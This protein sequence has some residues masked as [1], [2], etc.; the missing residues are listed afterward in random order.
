MRTVA[1]YRGDPCAARMYGGRAMIGR[2]ITA[3]TL[4]SVLIVATP[5]R[6]PAAELE[7]V[8]TGLELP[9]SMAFAPDGRLFV[10]EQHLGTIRIV[11]NGRLLP[12]PFARIDVLGTFEQGLLGIAVH[13]RFPE[14]PWIY[15][16][17][18][19]PV[20]RINRLIRIRAEGDR[21]GHREVLLDLLT[22]EAGYHN[23]GDLVFGSD[24][25]LYLTVGDVHDAARA[26][27]VNDLGGKVLRLAPDGS[28]PVD[29][30]FGPGN[31]VYSIGHR[32]SFG[33]CV[34]SATGDLWETEN[35]PSSYD[36]VNL[37]RPGANFGWPEQL[38]PGGRDRGFTD[39][40]LDFPD[41]IVPTGCVVWDGDLYFG[42]YA[43]AHV[44]RL[45]LPAGVGAR[46]RAIARLQ[47]GITDLAIGPE[48]DLYVAALDG[49]HR[50][51]ERNPAPIPDPAPVSSGDP[52]TWL[53]WVAA[54]TIAIVLLQLRLSR[55]RR[56][57]R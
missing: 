27:N 48:G 52:W 28:I 6:A 37:L 57:A 31:P 43:D 44:R 14:E 46:A 38:G 36:E 45:R 56:L 55:A 51:R 34:D 7:P 19:D 54:G 21:A 53:P 47:D 4:L 22:T 8:V 25:M 23:G 32:N 2:A 15:A 11:E 18:S 16:Y 12:E 3:T 10:A 20:L 29:N 1:T 5:G 33:I 42:A 49:I 40:V 35:G 17:F 24:G 39:P 41:Q 30:P 13:P 9:V 50:L 26:Q